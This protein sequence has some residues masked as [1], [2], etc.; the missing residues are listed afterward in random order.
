[1]RLVEQNRSQALE[2]HT[3]A[4]SHLT[5]QQ[6]VHQRDRVLLKTF[7]GVQSTSKIRDP[8]GRP[9]RNRQSSSSRWLLG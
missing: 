7:V 6:H 9:Q 5:P 4:F 3:A 1:M 2:A 8:Q